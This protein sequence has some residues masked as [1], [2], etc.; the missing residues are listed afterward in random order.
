MLRWSHTNSIILSLLFWL[1]RI[2]TH[3]KLW[4]NRGLWQ[5]IWADG[6]NRGGLRMLCELVVVG[7]DRLGAHHARDRDDLP[8][9]LNLG[10]L[11]LRCRT[12]LV[13]FGDRFS[14]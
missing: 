1:N 3:L 8:I 13:A 12:T 7:V 5:I 2:K 9:E 10:P 6:L 14:R 11:R 4:R